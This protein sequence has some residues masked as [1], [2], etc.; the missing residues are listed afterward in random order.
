MSDVLRGVV[1]YFE[2]YTDDVTSFQL[3][4]LVYS[5]GGDIWY[6]A[7][8]FQTRART[9][10]DER[11]SNA[12]ARTTSHYFSKSRTTHIV[13]T[14]L[15]DSKSQRVGQSVKV[16]LALLPWARRLCMDIRPKKT[17]HTSGRAGGAPGLAAAQLQRRQ[18]AAR[19]QVPH[20]QRPSTRG[21]V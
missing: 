15:C 21:V 1:V 3:K 14:N 9:H 12:C 8:S 17:R 2:G 20:R 4:K 19:G 7:W 16:R 18:E 5:H 6:A 11:G 13:C 10:T